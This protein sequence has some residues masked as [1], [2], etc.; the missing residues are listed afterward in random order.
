MYPLSSIMTPDPEPDWACVGVAGMPR[1][2]MVTTEGRTFATTAGTDRDFSWEGTDS[3]R[4]SA[5]AV[6]TSSAKAITGRRRIGIV[7]RRKRRELHCVVRTFVMGPRLPESAP[8]SH[9]CSQ[10]ESRRAEK[11]RGSSSPL[12]ASCVC[13]LLD[14]GE[15]FLNLGGLQLLERF[16]FNLSKPLPHHREALSHLLQRA[17]LI[18]ADT[19]AQPDDGLLSG[20]ER[21]ENAFK[22]VRHFRLVHMGIG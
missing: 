2:R 12:S 19:E 7:K 9:N 11:G 21:A 6:S 3:I 1:V 10:G 20:R 15:H 4:G 14:G 22:L 16:R 5:E 8:L 13:R 18:V 17:G